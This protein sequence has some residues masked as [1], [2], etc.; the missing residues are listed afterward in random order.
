MC[1]GTTAKWWIRKSLHTL[2][3]EVIFLQFN[4]D[5]LFARPKSKISMNQ[6]KI[7]FNLSKIKIMLKSVGSSK[8]WLRG[9]TDPDPREKYKPKTE[10]KILCSQCWKKEII[11]NVHITEW[12]IKL[13]HKNKWKKKAKYY[14][15]KILLLFKKHQ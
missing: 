6:R 9:S 5:I 7:K 3:V 13:L 12:F 2:L 4:F 15:S 10:K 11:K 1:C 14:F 8:F